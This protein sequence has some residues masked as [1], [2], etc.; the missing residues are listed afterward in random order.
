MEKYG[1]TLNKT[2][3]LDPFEDTIGSTKEMID[4]TKNLFL[5]KLNNTLI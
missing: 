1:Q 4:Q 5:I 3:A 2:G